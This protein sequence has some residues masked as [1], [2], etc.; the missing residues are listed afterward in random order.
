MWSR[1][2]FF[3]L[4]V[5]NIK[6]LSFMIDHHVRILYEIE[7]VSRSVSSFLDSMFAHVLRWFFDDDNLALLAWLILIICDVI[8]HV[9]R[10]SKLVYLS[11]YSSYKVFRDTLRER[12]KS[13][14]HKRLNRWDDEE[15]CRVCCDVLRYWRC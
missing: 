3:H 14:G 11:Y 10:T 15:W 7:H 1:T 8:W 6:K 4:Q 9:R 12:A 2:I 13:R 5:S